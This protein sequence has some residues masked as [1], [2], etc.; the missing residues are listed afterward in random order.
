M[1]KVSLEFL[2]F[3]ILE[4]ILALERNFS[5]EIIWFRKIAQGVMLIAV[6]IMRLY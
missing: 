2:F 5:F 6:I 1:N 4:V 3:L